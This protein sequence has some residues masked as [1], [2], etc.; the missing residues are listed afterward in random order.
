MTGGIETRTSRG[1]FWTGDRESEARGVNLPL[2]EEIA[3][4][5]GGRL[6]PPIGAHVDASQTLFGAP[7]TRRAVNA[8]PWLLLAALALLSFDYIRRA[9]EVHVS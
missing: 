9:T 1:W 8:V 6:L 3:R 2:L 5:S 7:R 4:V